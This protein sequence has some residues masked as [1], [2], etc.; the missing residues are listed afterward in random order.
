MNARPNGGNQPDS[1][2]ESMGE[3]RRDENGMRDS[4]ESQEGLTK[5]HRHVLVAK[6]D[7]GRIV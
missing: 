7:A 2:L 6:G 4:G 5:V 1:I 3:A